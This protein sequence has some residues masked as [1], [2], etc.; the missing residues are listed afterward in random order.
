MTIYDI[1]YLTIVAL[2]E[3]IFVRTLFVLICFI[4]YWLYKNPREDFYNDKDDYS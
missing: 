2:K 1:F 4:A 3:S